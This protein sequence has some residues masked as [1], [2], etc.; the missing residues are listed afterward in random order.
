[1]TVTESYQD[2][3]GAIIPIDLVLIKQWCIKEGFECDLG[4]NSDPSQ[5]HYFLY[6]T[7]R[8]QLDIE[9]EYIVVGEQERYF[10][11][12]A[13]PVRHYRPSW[14]RSQEGAIY[15]LNQLRDQNWDFDNVIRDKKGINAVLECLHA[16]V[17]ALE[18]QM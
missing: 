1:M 2:R 5:N 16:R 10:I 11:T 7:P 12:E 8:D 15:V 13:F 17:L 9:V 3:N 4:Q 6:I 18:A 14:A